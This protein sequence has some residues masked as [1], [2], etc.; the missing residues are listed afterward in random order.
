MSKKARH[1]DTFQEAATQFLTST[2][3]FLRLGTHRNHIGWTAM[4]HCVF[5]CQCP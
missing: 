5:H 4:N 3:G 1:A 2:R